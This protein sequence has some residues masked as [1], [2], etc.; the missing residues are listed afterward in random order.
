MSNIL[1]EVKQTCG[2][3]RREP[4]KYTCPKCDL[5]Y[6]SLNCYKSEDHLECTESFYKQNILEEIK[7][8]QTDDEQKNR[9]L[10][11][12]RRFEQ[13]GDEMA[14]DE[15]EEDYEDDEEDDFV[16][17][18]KDFDIN[19]TDF[20][21]IWNKLTS[22]E[23]AEFKSK[24]IDRKFSENQN[25]L[26][27]LF[28]ELTIWKPWWEKESKKN[29]NNKI[30]EF[31]N[32]EYNEKNSQS[33][34]LQ[35]NDKPIVLKDIKKLEELTKKPPNPNLV[36]NLVNIL[37][38]YVYTCRYFNGDI[39]EDP[40]ETIKVIWQLSPILRNNENIIYENVSQAIVASSNVILQNPQYSQPP[41]FLNLIL[42][43]I[44]CLLSSLENILSLLSDLYNLFH[45]ESQNLNLE[46]GNKPKKIIT[47]TTTTTTTN[48]HKS[49][50]R[51]LF[52]TEKKIYFYL[53]YMNSTGQRK[54]EEMDELIILKVLKSQVEIEKEKR[55]KELEMY[56]KDKDNI[57]ELIIRRGKKDE[58]KLDD[59]NNNNNN[60]NN[61]DLITEI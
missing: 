16:E 56:N 58:K 1:N 41:E 44:I 24:F 52:L 9:M 33:E 28:E 29:N 40:E 13:E 34:I 20:E 25:N 31:V 8:Q 32:D 46:S 10:E 21:A 53:V 19:S 11:M 17:R 50:Y 45:L 36:I 35:D 6:C 55:I 54:E 14:R 12:L 7:V 3:C 27:E 4:F 37:Y 18:F 51:K 15:F 5:K 47:T 22:S 49:Y 59:N 61:N 23:K 48:T 30:I 38:T 42:N 57:E 60:N 39:Y 43:D 2:I 26:S